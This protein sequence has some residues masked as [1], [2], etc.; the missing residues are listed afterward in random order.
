MQYLKITL[1]LSALLL[2]SSTTQA[3]QPKDLAVVPINP[4]PSVE[5]TIDIDKTIVEL[6][7]VVSFTF[8]SNKDG[9]ATLWNLGTSGKVHRIF[10]N[11]LGGDMH[12]IAKHKYGAGGP[13]DR[14]AFQATGKVGMEDVYLVWTRT[15]DAQPTDGRFLNTEALTKDLAVVDQLPDQDWATA[16]VTYEI[17]P[18]GYTRSRALAPAGRSATPLARRVFILA[19]GANVGRLTKTNEDAARFV[20]HTKALFQ[21]PEQH[22]RLIKN[23]RRADF[24]AGM[25]WLRDM[26]SKDDLV[27]IFYSGHGSQIPDDNGDETD[28]WDEGF[29]MYDAQEAGYARVEH[30][31]RDDQFAAWVDDLATDRVFTVLDS[32]FSA[33]LSR[34]MLIHARTKFYIGGELGQVTDSTPRTRTLTPSHNLDEVKGLILAASLEFQNAHEVEEGGL[35]LSRF[36]E[37]LQAEDNTDVAS[38]FEATK[39]LVIKQS[40]QLQQPIAMGNISLAKAL[41]LR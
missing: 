4:K 6:G 40:A 2:I 30:L 8:S 7:D 14:F 39:P 32:C 31:V 25:R 18:K 15:P 11:R 26:A 24:A 10:P 17:V 23:A 28:Q 16:K 19:M 20:T 1:A 36:L 33:G 37:Q 41:K 35:F 38:A 27:F 3:V 9:Y 34:S 12:V 22:I 29:V 5:L 13:N 21:V